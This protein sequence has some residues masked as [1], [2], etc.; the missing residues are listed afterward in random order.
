M[1]AQNTTREI[2]C[3]AASV[4]PSGAKAT[5]ERPRPP[6]FWQPQILVS[7][8]PAREEFRYEKLRVEKGTAY[9]AELDG[10][11]SFYFHDPKDET[12]FYGREIPLTLL[13][14]TEVSIKGPW[15][16]RP[17]VMTSLGFA[18]SLAV[19]YTKDPDVW[20]RGYTFFAGAVTVD[21][22]EQNALPLL[23]GFELWPV[24]AST[25]PEIS[26]LSK[27]V[28]FELVP[29]YRIVPCFMCA[30]EGRHDAGPCHLCKYAGIDV[31]ATVRGE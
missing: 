27:K 10:F 18:P 21:W 26:I 1:G 13:D 7:D 3:L 25:D 5:S 8:Y 23:P 16:S 30:G 6:Q 14:G 17:A 29:R 31:D 11:V 4:Y 2:T 28:G 22:F 9:F 15:S 12:G 20:A 19:S 24:D